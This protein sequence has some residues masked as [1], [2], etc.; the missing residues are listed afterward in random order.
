RSGLRV[1]GGAWLDRCQNWGID[2]S[3]FLMQS[4]SAQFSTTSDGSATL[5]RPIVSQPGNIP[6]VDLLAG[7]AIGRGSIAIDSPLTFLGADLN[8][9]GN[10]FCEDNIRF[11]LLGGFRA[12]RISEELD[13]RAR[14]EN[15]S[16]VDDTFRTLNMFTGGQ[17]G[18]AGE[19]RY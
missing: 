19:Y 4:T 14:R 2:G 6:A 17:V 7:P 5:G 8:A 16:E 11:D 13:I 3:F 12:I 15:I 18:F 9:R 1:E 10:L